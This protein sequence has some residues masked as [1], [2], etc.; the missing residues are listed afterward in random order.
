MQLI[1]HGNKKPYICN[2][3]KKENKYVYPDV[4]SSGK[5]EIKF[6]GNHHPISPQMALEMAEEIIRAVATIHKEGE[7]EK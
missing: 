7:E 1:L 3:D 4:D 6:I 2:M 5:P